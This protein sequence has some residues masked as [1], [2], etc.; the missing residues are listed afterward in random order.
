MF[1]QIA[2]DLPT[3]SALVACA[4]EIRTAGVARVEIGTLTLLNLGAGAVSAIAELEFD[5][6]YLDTKLV[7]FTVRT[8]AAGLVDS[9]VH[10]FSLHALADRAEVRQAVDFA[11]ANGLSVYTSTI[12]LS[13]RQAT[14]LARR[15]L[16]QGVTGVVAHG[17]GELGR[18]F[19]TSLGLVQ[20]LIASGVPAEQIVLAGGVNAASLAAEIADL[21]ENM[22]GVI[23]GRSVTDV[24]RP[25][26]AAGALLDLIERSARPQRSGSES[27]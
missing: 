21:P 16:E 26:E 20:R 1:L 15:H 17:T 3:E 2:I 13:P 23:V 14:T 18:A 19:R 25:D 11:S 5:F 4:R 24:A 8:L 22:A 12:G 7:D 6:I 27:G 10:A 9:G